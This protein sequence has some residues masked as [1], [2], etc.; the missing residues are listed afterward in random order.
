MNKIITTLTFILLFSLNGNAQ[1]DWIW[2]N[3]LPQGNHLHQVHVFDAN[4]VIA[5]SDAGIVMKTT[6]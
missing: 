1:Q 4:V 5:V 3:P 2:Q 6:N